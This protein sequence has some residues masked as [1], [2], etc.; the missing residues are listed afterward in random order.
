M[1]FA[2]FPLLLNTDCADDTAIF[3]DDETIWLPSDL[4]CGGRC[5]WD[6][7]TY[8]PDCDDD[9]GFSNED[10]EQVIAS[11]VDDALLGDTTRA[12]MTAEQIIDA[13]EDAA[14]AIWRES[15]SWTRSNRSLAWAFAPGR[16]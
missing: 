1:T 12:G 16:W 5:E 3:Y 15:R 13:A 10:V 11:W 4:A 8:L 6:R 7:P 14:R 2:G 9:D